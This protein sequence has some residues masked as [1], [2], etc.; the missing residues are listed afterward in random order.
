MIDNSDIRI[1]SIFQV[2]YMKT[3]EIEAEAY[4]V[5][6]Q[7][8]DLINP[9]MII[10]I[11]VDLLIEKVANLTLV[12]DNLE[13]IFHLNDILG[14]LFIETQTVMINEH[15]NTNKGR[16][17]FTCAHELG[18]WYLHKQYLIKNENQLDLFSSRQGASIVCR[19]S[20]AKEPIEWQ[21]D[22]FA[23]AVLMPTENY[24]IS[25]SDFLSD[26]KMSINDPGYKKTLSN[27]TGVLTMI[28]GELA[29][30]YNV[31]KEAARV[32]LSILDLLPDE[33]GCL[34]D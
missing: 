21:A 20:C 8:T 9:H 29:D 17:N 11:D 32:R 23:G 12:I 2:K 34:F 25:F 30:Q 7:F 6:K 1:A 22:F 19:S 33:K 3:E 16:F 13:N 5:V 31:S 28:I 18:H 26:N 14:A 27:N 4:Y 15:L 10:P 24:S